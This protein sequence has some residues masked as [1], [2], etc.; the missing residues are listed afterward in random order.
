MRLTKA[1]RSGVAMRWIL[2][3][4]AGL[5][6]SGRAQTPADC[7]R[8]VEHFKKGWTRWNACRRACKGLDRSQYPTAR[9]ADRVCKPPT[10]PV[11]GNGRRETDEECDDGN[12]VAGDGCDERCRHEIPPR[13]GD[14]ERNGGEFCDDGNQLSGDGCDATCKLEPLPIVCGDGNHVPVPEEECDD[15]N[16][17]PGDGCDADCRI[18]PDCGNGRLDYGE[19]CDDG[20][21][22]SDDGCSDECRLETLPPLTAIRRGADLNEAQWEQMVA[23]LSQAI[24][25]F[26]A[27]EFR[28]ARRHIGEALD[29]DIGRSHAYVHYVQ[30]R[31]EHRLNELELALAAAERATNLARPP[32]D[33]QVWVLCDALESIIKNDNGWVYFHPPPGEVHQKGRI[34]LETQAALVGS[35]IERFKLVQERLRSMDSEMPLQLLLPE[36]R[37]LANKMAFAVVPGEH[38][39]ASV[40]VQTVINEGEGSDT[41][42]RALLWSGFALGLGGYVGFWAAND[43]A[44]EDA[45][46]D[47]G[48]AYLRDRMDLFGHLAVGSAVIGGTMA[49]SGLAWWWLTD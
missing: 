22:L 2:L 23:P 6:S 30:A 25:L 34:F 48:D 35:N 17:T 39:A 3:V 15:G 19:G 10:P 20:N 43:S 32:D 28:A 33:D 38:T 29:T 41:G 49:L 46:R 37:Y 26:N 16:R 9:E 4:F 18:E 1:N 12:Q 40:Y 7:E 11:C 8:A 14:G 47:P 36:G 24:F 45:K 44:Y 31:I 27:G 42:P 21:T 13:C 5:T